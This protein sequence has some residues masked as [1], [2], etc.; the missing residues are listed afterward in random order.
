MA[1]PEEDD[2]LLQQ[3]AVDVV[4]ALTAAGGL[5]DHRDEHRGRG[6][7]RLERGR[8]GGN[9]RGGHVW[10]P[11][12][13]SAIRCGYGRLV[14]AVRIDLDIGQTIGRGDRILVLDV[15]YVAELRVIRDPAIDEGLHG[16]RATEL[17]ADVRAAARPTRGRR[18]CAGPRDCSRRPRSSSASHRGVGNGD[19][20]R[21]GDGAQ[22]QQHL[23]AMCGAVAVLLAQLR[24]VPLG[25]ALVLL[26]A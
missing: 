22:G 14:V 12:V 21:V 11:S 19:P 15:A 23:D 4:G 6:P 18:P 1:S 16:L 9:G 10:A 8:A 13:T 26:V 20:L 5:D 7:G 17:R 3:P 2:P 24:L 25:D